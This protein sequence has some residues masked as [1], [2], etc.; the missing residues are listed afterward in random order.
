MKKKKEIQIKTS[1]HIATSTTATLHELVCHSCS[2]SRQEVSIETSHSQLVQPL[3]GGFDEGREQHR[4]SRMW[5][6]V[7]TLTLRRAVGLVAVSVVCQQSLCRHHLFLSVSGAASSEVDEEPERS[8][9]D[10]AGLPD[11][12][13]ADV[14][15]EEIEETAGDEEGEEDRDES[16]QTCRQEYRSGVTIVSDEE[17]EEENAL[18]RDG[19]RGQRRTQLVYQDYGEDW[20][21]PPQNYP[22]MQPKVEPLLWQKDVRNSSD[23]KWAYHRIGTCVGLVAPACKE[24]RWRERVQYQ[25]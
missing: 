15:E 12:D 16:M 25:V 9:P 3:R 7:K 2:P 5:G 13:H 18:Q 21:G 4:S 6:S 23:V 14:G 22:E 17:A 11:E 24:K 10:P 1:S 20:R 8:D 19:M